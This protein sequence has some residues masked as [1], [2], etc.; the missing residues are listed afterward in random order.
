MRETSNVVANHSILY[1]RGVYPPGDFRTV[2]KYGQPVLITEDPNLE[3]YIA[4]ILKQVERKSSRPFH[5]LVCDRPT[6]CGGAPG[7]S[8]KLLLTYI[9]PTGWLLTN[10]IKKLVLVVLSAESRVVRERWEFDIVLMEPEINA[11]DGSVYVARP[12]SVI[13]SLFIRGVMHST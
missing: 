5:F 13:S 10:N 6:P 12:H 8:W 4:N 9:F 1:H 11:E 3:T 2:K 7:K